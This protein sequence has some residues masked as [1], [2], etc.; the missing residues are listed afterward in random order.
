MSWKHLA[1]CVAL[2]G[3]GAIV[4]VAGLEALGVF[5]ALACPLV[6]AAMVWMMV[7]GGARGH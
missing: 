6:M 3:I 2:T 4:V 7:R 1:G 5:I